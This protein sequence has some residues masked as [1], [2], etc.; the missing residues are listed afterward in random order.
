M[1]VRRSG[2]LAAVLFGL[3]WAAA[4][5]PSHAESTPPLPQAEIRQ[6]C[7]EQGGRFEQFWRYNDQGTQW[8]HVMSCTTDAGFVTCQDRVCRSGQWLRPGG[9]K[10]AN[11]TEEDGDTVQFPTDPDAIARALV[12][13]A[14]R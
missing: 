7:T 4:S 5:G 3:G 14:E 1:K 6:V 2:A 10:V 12:A 8:G 13:L 9:G 11:K